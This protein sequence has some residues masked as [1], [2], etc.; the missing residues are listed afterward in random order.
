MT[1]AD[2]K[3][4]ADHFR[5]PENGMHTQVVKAGSGFAVRY[6]YGKNDEISNSPTGPTEK[7]F[8]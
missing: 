8:H 7:H 1:N 4:V 2:A 5:S 6:V 3:K